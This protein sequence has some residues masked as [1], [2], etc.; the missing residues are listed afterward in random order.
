VSVPRPHPSTVSPARR[1][2]RR[3]RSR[4]MGRRRRRSRIVGRGRRPGHVDRTLVVQL[5]CGVTP[6]GRRTQSLIGIFERSRRAGAIVCAVETRP[7]RRRNRNARQEVA[8][9]RRRSP[10]HFKSLRT[11]VE[12]IHRCK[13]LPIEVQRLLMVWPGH[14]S[15]RS[16]RTLGDRSTVDRY[17]ALRGRGI[18][19]ATK[20]RPYGRGPARRVSVHHGHRM[21]DTAAAA[22]TPSPA[23]RIITPGAAMVRQPAPGIA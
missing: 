17:Q 23:E 6:A 14:C 16:P 2:M 10:G 12:S 1:R 4:V 7:L 19:T 5:N 20:D 21:P 13:R 22:R 3:W 18:C 8:R 15:T 9:P 11:N